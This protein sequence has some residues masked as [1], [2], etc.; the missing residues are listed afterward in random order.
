VK[1]GTR[2]WGLIAAVVSVAVL[3]AGWF[4]GVSPLLGARTLAE[5][6]LVD[7]VA[8]N[9]GISTKIATLAQQKE[10]LDDYEK[11]AAELEVVIPS[12]IKAADFI[13]SLND[14]AG[15]SNVQI[16]S[17]T[18][19]DPLQYVAPTGEPADEKFAPNPVTDSRI[20]SENFLLVP[21]SVGVRGGWNE[22]LAFTHGVQTS[23]RLMLVTTVSTTEDQGAFTTTLSG[24]MYVLV[25]PPAPAAASGGDTAS[26]SDAPAEG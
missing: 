17:I 4:L 18:L 22:V 2:V 16:E 10:K 25:R 13:R 15:A 24:T 7:A 11:R 21:V 23:S 20:T 8:Q 6:Q 12:G 26:G 1:L 9:D 14:L 19:S 5:Q 3:A